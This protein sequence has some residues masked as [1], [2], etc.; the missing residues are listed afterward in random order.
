VDAGGETNLVDELPGLPRGTMYLWSPQ[1][2]QRF[3]KV[4]IAKKRTADVSATPTLG[5]DHVEARTLAAVDIEQLRG[6][7]ATAVEEKEANDPAALKKRDRRAREAA[8]EG[9]KGREGRRARRG[10][11]PFSVEQM[12]ELAGDAQRTGGGRRR[13]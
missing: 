8:R 12:R 6:A 11:W 3:E 7:L 13:R 5:M 2:L 4:H 1:W 10:A 9:R